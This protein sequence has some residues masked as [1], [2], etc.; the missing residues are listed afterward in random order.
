MTWL[1][2]N[3]IL[4]VFSQRYRSKIKSDNLK[5]RTIISNFV[6]DNDLIRNEHENEIS[7]RMFVTIV[8]W[9]DCQKLNEISSYFVQFHFSSYIFLTQTK[10]SEDVKKTRILIK[11]FL[12]NISILCVI[13]RLSINRTKQNDQS[14][15]DNR[16]WKYYDEN[17]MWNRKK[18]RRRIRKFR[19]FQSYLLIR[20]NSTSLRWMFVESWNLIFRVN[21]IR[22]FF[23]FATS[24]WSIEKFQ[25]SCSN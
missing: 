21:K 4:W 14:S 11:L 16:D 1:I 7:N 15:T 17:R 6:F 8:T 2:W 18:H 10:V 3:R 25:S 5:S 20:E 9:L 12:L 13:Q 24:I 23:M 22:R 19:S